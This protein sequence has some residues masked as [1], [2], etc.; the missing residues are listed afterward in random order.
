MKRKLNFRKTNWN[1]FKTD[2]DSEIRNLAPTTEDYETFMNMVKRA[3]RNHI[4]KCCK[5]EY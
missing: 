4:P 5:T 2:L 1:G 3:S